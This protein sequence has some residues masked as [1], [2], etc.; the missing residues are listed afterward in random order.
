[1]ATWRDIA[2]DSEFAARELLS[3]KR[4]RSCASRA[5][6]A[7]YSRMTHQLIHQGFRRGVG[8]RGNPA[9][10]ALSGMVSGTL[11]GLTAPR[12]RRLKRAIERLYA[13]RV[14]ADYFPGRTLDESLAWL[15]V[16]EMSVAMTILE[17]SG[18]SR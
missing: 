4:W 13:Y 9:H 3:R 1:M 7:V 10:D 17:E 14:V 16:G 6:Y 5:Y 15:A 8:F 18:G 2:T 12:R 11:R